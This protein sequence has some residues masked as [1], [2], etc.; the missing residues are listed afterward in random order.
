MTPDSSSPSG[1]INQ[2]PANWEKRLTAASAVAS[3]LTCVAAPFSTSHAAIN[4]VLFAVSALI[5]VTVAALRLGDAVR[6]KRI[7]LM[8]L[9]STL[10]ILSVAAVA[11]AGWTIAHPP[12]PR[13]PEQKVESPPR[14]SRDISTRGD[15]SPVITGDRNDVTI[16]T[17]N[18]GTPAP[19][20]KRERK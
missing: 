9:A 19:K 3:L 16:Q 18:N 8:P 1:R 4:W 15:N 10:V 13:I 12:K 6:F 2:L 14:Y 7:L 5:L 20:N 17:S 11:L